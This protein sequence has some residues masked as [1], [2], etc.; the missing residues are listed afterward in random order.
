MTGLRNGGN[1]AVQKTTAV[2]VDAHAEHTSADK[3][4]LQ[5][6]VDRMQPAEAHTEAPQ[7]GQAVNSVR[8]PPGLG[9][10]FPPGLSV[11]PK[12]AFQAPANSQGTL[13]EGYTFNSER[14]LQVCPAPGESSSSVFCFYRVLCHLVL[15]SPAT[16]LRWHLCTAA[17]VCSLCLRGSAQPSVCTILILHD[18][19]RL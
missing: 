4:R 18:D 7:F 6:E 17:C 14:A 13:K 5:A 11:Q 3:A 12:F 15:L 10:R 8:S 16:F 1:S 2:P 9:V 19:C